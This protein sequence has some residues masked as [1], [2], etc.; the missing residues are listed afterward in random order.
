MMYLILVFF[1]VFA[2]ADGSPV[3]WPFPWAK[4]CPVQWSSV[5]GRYTLVDNYAGEEVSIRISF[6][7]HRL[8][9]VLRIARYDRHGQILSDGYSFV[10]ENQNVFRVYLRPH[11]P[12]EHP[13][14]A[15]IR[16]Y[17][18]DARL[19][20]GGDS[21]VPFLS[22]I[23]MGPGVTQESLYRLVRRPV[24]KVDLE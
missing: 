11:E 5:V 1:S 16:L 14:W 2:R 9:H 21:L 18:N 23:D 19:I 6:V 15:T 7:H 10:T 3:P 4:D 17:F 8:L 24:A 13:Y 20:C 12:G 22:L